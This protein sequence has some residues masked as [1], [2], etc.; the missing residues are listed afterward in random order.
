MTSLLTRKPVKWLHRVF[1]F[2]FFF[3][4]RPSPWILLDVTWSFSPQT[5]DIMSADCLALLSL[6]ILCCAH[7]LLKVTENCYFTVCRPISF[8]CVVGGSR[9]HT[10]RFLMSDWRLRPR[11][12][13]SIGVKLRSFLGQCEIMKAAATCAHGGGC[14]G[15][16]WMCSPNGCGNIWTQ[17]MQYSATHFF[18]SLSFCHSTWKFAFFLQ[19]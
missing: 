16:C 10:L 8:T 13:R 4:L 6:D 11:G 9:T 1:W 2:F 17:I 3:F 12:Y 7:L 19:F 14:S 18:A 5:V 15:L